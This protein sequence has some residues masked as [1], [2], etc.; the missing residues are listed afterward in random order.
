MMKR[1]GEHFWQALMVCP[2]R[3]TGRLKIEAGSAYFDFV[4]PEGRDPKLTKSGPV[5]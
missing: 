5:A 4:V 1:R 2:G 3:A